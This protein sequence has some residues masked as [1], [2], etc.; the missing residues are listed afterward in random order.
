MRQEAVKAKGQPEEWKIG[1]KVERKI[2]GQVLS[3]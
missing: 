2:N 1:K 3:R